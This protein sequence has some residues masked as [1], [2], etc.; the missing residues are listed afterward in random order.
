MPDGVHH[1]QAES[2]VEL[3]QS[4]RSRVEYGMELSAGVGVGIARTAV[5]TARRATR[6]ALEL[7]REAASQLPRL[8]RLDQIHPGTRI[9]LGQLVEE[10]R[11]RAPDGILFLFEDRAY[12]ARDFNERIDNV[13]RGLLEI[14]VRQG[15]H[16]G[17]LMGSR[18][19]A[20]TLMMAISRLGAV[21]VL[22]R[23]DGDV[24]R[25]A[26]LGQVERVIA[27]PERATLASVLVAPESY[28]LGCGGGPRSLGHVRRPVAV[29]P[30]RRGPG[31]VAASAGQAGR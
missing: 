17:V 5:G 19:S 4:V 31:D 30:H 26:S 10:R 20:V 22:V 13:V 27:D 1:P 3:V 25:E 2:S 28:V 11:R 29:P 6:T 24:A 18:P 8:T 23:P 12:T 15:E 16:V 7:S 14:G 21:A 9:S